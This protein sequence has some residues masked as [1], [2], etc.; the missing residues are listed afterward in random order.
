MARDI[1]TTYNAWNIN[2]DKFNQ[3]S[4]AVEGQNQTLPEKTEIREE[5]IR[6]TNLEL[7]NAFTC[8]AEL[9]LHQFMLWILSL[10]VI[11]HRRVIS[12]RRLKHW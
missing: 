5:P 9:S 7:S 8:P 2:E 12:R 4:G 1:T 11:M 10:I 3:I 6:L